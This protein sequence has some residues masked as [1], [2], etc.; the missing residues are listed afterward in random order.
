[1]LTLVFHNTSRV[2]VD[3][4]RRGRVAKAEEPS[5]DTE[6]VKIAIR[7]ASRSVKWYPVLVM[8]LVV[9]ISSGALVGAINVRTEFSETDFLPEDWASIDTSHEI[10]DRFEA[11]RYSEVF[12]FIK[13]E[14]SIPQYIATVE[15]LRQIQELEDALSDDKYVVK[16]GGEARMESVLFFVQKFL[17][18]NETLAAQYDTDSDLMPDDSE[19]VE[20]LFDFLMTYDGIAD[21]LT[22][23]TYSERM[24][25]L[26]HLNDNNYYDATKITIYVQV[27]TTAEM[28]ELYDELQ[29]DLPDFMGTTVVI[30]GNAIMT[31]V[32]IDAL[33]TGQIYSTVLAI[34]LAFILLVILYRSIGLGLISMVPVVLST[35]WILGTMYFFGISLNV[36][37]VMV[38]ALTIGL[39]LDYAIYIVTRYQ[40]ERKKHS[41]DEAINVTIKGTGSALF[42]SGV[43]T[44]CGFAVLMLSPIPIIAHFGLIIATTIIYCGVLAVVVLP[45]MLGGWERFKMRSEDEEEK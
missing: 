9:V 30:T 3:R 35:L 26:L 40:E 19:S 33:Q 27:E 7:T 1:I 32:T 29:A 36:L 12:I 23:E 4:Y 10:N 16:L 45:I 43:T 6:M 31:I 24:P 34:I 42:I 8:T 39:G 5:E 15:M 11:G 38:T 25:R 21:P 17:D 28:R 44:V 18:T 14:L 41:I 13:D 20:A 22:G 2:L 37:T